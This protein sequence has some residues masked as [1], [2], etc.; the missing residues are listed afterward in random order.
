MNRIGWLDAS[1][2][3][4]VLL[5]VAMHYVGGLESRSF[6]SAH[7]LDVFYGLLRLATPFFMFTFGLA[8]YITA[9]KKIERNGLLNYYKHNVFKRM[10]YI[11]CAREI[12]VIILAFHYPHVAD[13]LISILLFEKFAPG[14]EILIFYFFAFLLAP[15]NVVFLK[16]FN[17][18]LYVAFWLVIYF[19][20]VYIGSNYVD[21]SS[22]NAMRFL[23][24]DIY[25]FFPFLIVVA[26]AMLVSKHFLNTLDRNRFLV[27]GLVLGLIC[28][29]AGFALLNS[30]TTEIWPA[31]SRADFK[32]PPHP[33]YMIFYLGEVFIVITLVA[34]LSSKTPSFINNILSLL[35]RNTLVSYVVHY[36]FFACVPIA[37]FFGG[38]AIL[39]A[40]FL[41]IICLLSY[42]GIKAWDKHKASKK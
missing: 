2:G 16:R 27:F 9:S 25:A 23:F 12:I 28:F 30:L 31:L 3:L 36:T 1:R 37:A 22:S 24:F 5:L 4:A 8:F 41:I 10:L 39:E 6:I 34:L 13:N 14:G 35:G 32:A 17:I 18:V 7:T 42:F 20:A 38:G 40:L 21:R 26:T 11:L 19:I 15:L 33:G 29:M